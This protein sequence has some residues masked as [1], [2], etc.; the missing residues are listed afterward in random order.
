MKN[1]QNFVEP[2]DFSDVMLNLPIGMR[3]DIKEVMETRLNGVNENIASDWINRGKEWLSRK[4]LNWIIN[5]REEDLAKKINLLNIVDPTDFSNIKSVESIYLGGGIDKTKP[6]SEVKHWREDTEKFFGMDNV[7]VGEDMVRVSKF[8]KIDK[9]KYPKPLIFNPMRNELVRFEGDFSKAH[10]TWKE[11]GYDVMEP[12]SKEED[13]FKYWGG[14]MNTD[15]VAGDRRIILACDTNIISS[16][17]GAGA[18]TWGETEL[19]TYAGLNTFIWL[20]DDWT[21]KDISPWIVPAITKIV[22]NK[23]EYDLLLTSIK[24]FNG[25]LSIGIPET[26]KGKNQL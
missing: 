25:D 23:K 22:R 20:N 14:K 16:N 21:I 6:E 19:T 26:Y 3:R 10:S 4:A 8:G 15:M 18:G 5:M 17:A 1:Y 7:V 24:V 12:C 11:G 2:E 13:L 9:S